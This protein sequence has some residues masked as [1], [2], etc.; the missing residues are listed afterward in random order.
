MKK[1]LSK[2]TRSNNK[3]KAY[4]V[5]LNVIIS[6]LRFIRSF[7]F[8]KFL[9]F[10]ELGIISL[11][12]TIISFFGMLQIG[13]L[14]GGYRIFSA[15]KSKPDEESVNNHV[16]TFFLI[17][18]VIVFGILGIL[19]LYNFTFAYDYLLISLAIFFGIVTLVDNW[20]RNM[21]S[22]YMS[23]KELN[24]LELYSTIISFVFL[25]TIPHIGITGAFLVVFMKP[26][27]FLILSTIRNKNLLP[28][29]IEFNIK[30]IKWILS[31]GF[32]PFL[33]GV[34]VVLETQVQNWGIVYYLT[35][36]D[37]GKFY[38]PI[39][40]TSIFILIPVALN[41]IYFP[42][43]IK[44][45]TDQ[46]FHIVRKELKTFS[47]ILGVYVLIAFLLT[48]LFI[49]PIISF[50]FPKHLFA[51]KYIWLIYPGL[52]AFIFVQ[53]IQILLNA[54]IQLKPIFWAQAFSVL[55][56]LIL[57]IIFDN[58]YG[59]SLDLIAIIKSIVM[60]FGLVYY[61]LSY[62]ALKKKVWSFNIDRETFK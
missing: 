60:I 42:Q 22:A 19:K 56:L 13:F 44:N 24:F 18:S 53:P 20:V 30:R 58:I 33:S 48:Y 54:S 31:F 38:L 47:L 2:L 15:Q 12:T 23:F 25:V 45:F 8:L 61:I 62:F 4:F 51:I 50:I 41:K 5:V 55:L 39:M 59:L 16:Y 17:L 26:F 36:E 35:V 11:V 3:H 49:N 14:N 27:S 28:K 7:V 34:F 43:V 1:L 46:K 40:Y 37:L 52:I 57:I 10:S 29:K 9:V 32:I 21:L 6:L